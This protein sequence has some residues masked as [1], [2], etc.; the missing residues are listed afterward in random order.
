VTHGDLGLRHRSARWQFEI[1]LFALRYSDRIVSVSTG[2]LTPGGRDIVQSV[3]AAS[4]SIHGIETSL[5]AQ[6]TDRL[7]THAVLNYTRGEQR[8]D[9]IDEAADRVPPLNGNLVLRYNVTDRWQ[10]DAWLRAA[11]R[12]DRLS[13]R[14]V[15]TISADN[16]TDKQYRTHG[17]GIDAPGRN[18]TATI[19]RRW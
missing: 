7:S 17:S 9:A 13:N 3:N 4:S 6:L 2:A 19:R 12:Q 5:K 15:V 11:A 1:M 8:V 18:L 16:L 14:D 10:L